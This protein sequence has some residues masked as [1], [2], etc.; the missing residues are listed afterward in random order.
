MDVVQGIHRQM[1]VYA[2]VEYTKGLREEG[3]LQVAATVLGHT[4][5]VFIG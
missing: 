4:V 3:N 1:H 5:S 2:V